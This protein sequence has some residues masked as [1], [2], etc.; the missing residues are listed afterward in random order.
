M[1]EAKIVVSNVS[2]AY[3]MYSKPTDRLVEALGLSGKTL[4]IEFF[5]LADVSFSLK[6]GEILGIMGRNGSGKSTLL[7]IITGVLTPSW[8]TVQVKGKISSLLE[9]GIGFN[10]EYTGIENIYF[11]GTLMGMSKPQMDAKMAEILDFAEIGDYIHQPVKTYS[12]GMFARLAFSCAVH[13]EPDVLLVDEILSVGDMRFQA[14]CFKKFKRFKE[15]GVTIIYVGHDISIMRTFCDTCMWLDNGRVVDIG[16]PVYI[17]SKYTEFMYL[18]D[19]D[20]LTAYSRGE[21]AAEIEPDGSEIPAEDTAPNLAKDFD[22]AKASRAPLAH[23]GSCVGAIANIRL[24]NEAGAPI[25]YFAPGDTVV[26]RFEIPFNKHLA[27]EHLSA[28]MSIKNREGTDLLVRTTF[29]QKLS[30]EARPLRIEFKLKTLLNTGEYYLVV[31]LENRRDNVI[32][33]YEYIEGAVYFKIYSDAEIYG[34]F[35]PEV[36][37]GVIQI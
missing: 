3:K 29:D 35:L 25:E 28:A 20:S 22:R 27:Y 36:E 32:S 4:H 10:S 37:I 34:V 31:A 19:S 5:A 16:E 8:G 1:A 26:V 23:W 12:S 21:N 24:T 18:D 33:Y 14:K 13:V 30:L 6:A 9:L 2:K 15:Q 11:Y 17:S 7:K